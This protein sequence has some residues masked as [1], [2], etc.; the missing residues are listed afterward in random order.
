[1]RKP[2]ATVARRKENQIQ[3]GTTSGFTLKYSQKTG[4]EEFRQTVLR[5]FIMSVS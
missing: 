4:V 1:M 2:Q 5:V 3:K